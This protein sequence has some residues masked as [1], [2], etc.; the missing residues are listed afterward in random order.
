MNKCF[1]LAY[2]SQNYTLNEKA[3]LLQGVFFHAA[4][5]LVADTI[6]VSGGGSYDGV[7]CQSYDI[8]NDIWS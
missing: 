8:K 2:E 5:V 3:S 6:V 4:S 7:K 1:L